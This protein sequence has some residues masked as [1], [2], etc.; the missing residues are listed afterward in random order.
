MSFHIQQKSE[1]G[2][3][4]TKNEKNVEKLQ[5]DTLTQSESKTD[6]KKR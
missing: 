1:K 2:L 4:A 5:I 6:I 3:A